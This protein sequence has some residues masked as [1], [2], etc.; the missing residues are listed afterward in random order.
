MLSSHDTKAITRLVAD[1]PATSDLKCTMAT[2]SQSRT[3]PQ[4]MSGNLTKSIPTTRLDLYIVQL[5]SL[6]L[7]V[8]FPGRLWTLLVLPYLPIG[9]ALC[10]LRL[11]MSVQAILLLLIFPEG[12]LKRYILVIPLDTRL[13]LCECRFMLRVFFSVLGILVTTD[14]QLKD[15]KVQHQPYLNDTWYTTLGCT[16]L[17]VRN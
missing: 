6:V 9:I 8:R 12:A 10:L 2:S 4:D 16:V 7:Y 1:D 14:G 13:R 15:T 17:Q 3:Q 5:T 11:C